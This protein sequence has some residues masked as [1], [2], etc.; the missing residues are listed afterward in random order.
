MLSASAF[1]A[2]VS[3]R[4]RGWSAS[5]LRAALR[6]IETPYAWAMRQR[7]RRYDRGRAETCRVDVPV[8][9]VGNITLGGTGK[10]PLVEWLAR[11]LRERGVRVALVSR[12]YGATDGR[13][14]DEALELEQKL[15]DVPHVQNRDRVAGARLAIDEF[16][17]QLVLLDDG[18]QHRRLARDLDIVVLDATEPFGCEHVFPRGLL[19]EPL[20]GLSRADLLVLSRADLVTADRRAEIRRRALALAPQAGWVEARHAPRVWRSAAGQERAVV[21]LSACRVAAFCG[22]GNPE[23]FRRT[24]AAAGCTVVAFREFAD[25]Y[26]YRREDMEALSRWAAEADIDAVM[27]THK[28]LVKI[29]VERLGDKPLWALVVGLEVLSGEEALTARLSAVLPAPEAYC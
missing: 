16:D 1:H 9:S 7:N 3:G 12:G 27:T 4:K 24:L 22:I 2:L 17:S 13:A 15:P 28:D 25:H 8:V 29:G 21:E 10:T 20:A 5:L 23:G 14:N 6:A 26:A 11:W 18:F 19:R